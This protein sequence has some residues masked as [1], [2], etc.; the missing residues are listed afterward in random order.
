M[1][2]EILYIYTKGSFGDKNTNLQLITS[3]Q[4]H[5]DF[6]TYLHIE[7]SQYYLNAKPEIKRF[8]ELNLF[9]QGFTEITEYNSEGWIM[10]ESWS[11]NEDLFFEFA[12]YLSE[13]LKLKIE[14][15]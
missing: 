10:L 3:N 14:I 8:K 1:K 12:T 2:P 6:I 11:S 7:I 9:R 5:L 13:Q 15:I 4:E